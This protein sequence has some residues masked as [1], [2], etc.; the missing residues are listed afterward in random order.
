MQKPTRT[1]QRISSCIV[2]RNKRNIRTV[3]T[4]M[5]NGNFIS[6]FPLRGW[7]AWEIGSSNTHQFELTH[8][9]KTLGTHFKRTCLGQRP[10]RNHGCDVVLLYDTCSLSP[11][12]PTV[13]GPGLGPG[14][15]PWFVI[16]VF[17]S[18]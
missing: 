1:N 18:E 6:N 2:G 13:L 8:G 12:Y 7:N 4:A 15:R 14:I 17:A 16:I 5:I 10:D 3:S 11:H 9:R